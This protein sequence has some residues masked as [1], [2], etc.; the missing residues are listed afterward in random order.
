LYGIAN[1]ELSGEEFNP[2]SLKQIQENASFSLT[3]D[4]LQLGA[5]KNGGYI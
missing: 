2:S 4:G 1:S 3:W 5:R